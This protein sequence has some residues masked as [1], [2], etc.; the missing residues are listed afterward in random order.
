MFI[1]YDWLFDAL[2]CC[3]VV[4][5][6]SRP[7][8]ITPAGHSRLEALC[9]ERN[10][11]FVTVDDDTVSFAAHT[12]ATEAKAEL[13]RQQ[14]ALRRAVAAPD[15]PTIAARDEA[16]RLFVAASDA[17][18]LALAEGSALATHAVNAEPAQET[19][20]RTALATS[21]QLAEFA[22]QCK[23]VTAAEEPARSKTSLQDLQ[24]A[25]V[26]YRQEATRCKL[27]LGLA[28][29][30]VGSPAPRAQG[31]A[32]ALQRTQT[33]PAQKQART[34]LLAHPIESWSEEQV[35]EWIGLIGLPTSQL[36]F[37]KQ[38]L[39]KDDVDGNELQAWSLQFQ[40][41]GNAKTLEKK[42]KKIGADDPAALAKHTFE[43]HEAAQGGAPAENKLKAA[44]DAL[45]AARTALRQNRVA[46]ESQVV[47]LVSL[48]SQHF[49][50]LHHL[51]EVKQFM[52]T[53]GLGASDRRTLDDYEHKEPLVQGRNQLLRA[54]YD[55]ALVCLK[56]FPIRGDM[57]AYTSEVLR[58]Q[59]LQHPCQQQSDLES[60]LSLRYIIYNSNR[61]GITMVCI[62]RGRY[63]IRYA[64]AFE[65]RGSMY[66]QMEFFQRGSLRHWLESA[67]PPDATQRRSVLRQ[68]LVALVCIHSQNLAHCD[69]K[70]EVSFLSGNV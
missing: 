57:R 43:L 44:Q 69:I 18:G 56:V 1:L 20:W 17:L 33:T 66:L 11:H 22:T 8:A 7:T 39:V 32:E 30:E 50:E 13:D 41:S 29:G 23:L 36:E 31:G 6:S 14:E 62:A 40:Q 27:M 15:E 49:P 60:R 58:V 38:A 68:V 24:A 9:A 64:T 42:L 61:L 5:V 34:E 65:D 51:D 10:G 45:D 4:L 63:I 52:Q 59:Q 16:R 46:L 19:G 12:K 70:G 28:E 67:T 37:V 48:S 35:Q 47:H 53:D 3:Q 21:N 54:T 55:G 25:D 26:R 2:G